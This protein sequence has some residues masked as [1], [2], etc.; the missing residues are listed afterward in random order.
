MD[1]N[2]FHWSDNKI[3]LIITGILVLIIGIYQPVLG[4]IGALVFGYLIYYTFIETQNKNKEVDKY[5]EALSGEFE[6]ATKHAIFNM[7]FPL[8]IIDE[9]GTIT[10]YNT[11]FLNMVVEE[12]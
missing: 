3:Y 7:P 9:Q 4:M 2:L 6:S 1:K 11:P 12:E 8:V 10:W 5:I